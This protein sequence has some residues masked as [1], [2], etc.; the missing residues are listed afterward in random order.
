MRAFS[1][2]RLLILASALSLPCSAPAMEFNLVDSTLVLTGNVVDTDL[3]KIK[4]SLDPSK[5]KLIVMHHNVGGD[6]WNALRIG[7][8]IRDSG[9]PTT[10]SGLCV[11]AC[12]LIFLG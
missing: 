5:V 1:L 11:S 2:H 7:E 6:L 10:V 8:R 12:G 9:I 3:A 4:D